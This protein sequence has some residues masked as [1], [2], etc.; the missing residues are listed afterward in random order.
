M[1]L[2][3]HRQHISVEKYVFLW[4]LNENRENWLS[5]LSVVS[6]SHSM[7]VTFIV[8]LCCFSIIVTRD[9]GIP[10]ALRQTGIAH[11]AH[12]KANIHNKRTACSSIACACHVFFF[13]AMR[14]FLMFF[15]PMRHLGQSDN[16]L[17]TIYVQRHC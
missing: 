11:A 8:Q 1:R 9:T 6:F 4:L 13:F 5:S 16:D 17:S 2:S 15:F 7:Q 14:R 3:E 10:P 12:T